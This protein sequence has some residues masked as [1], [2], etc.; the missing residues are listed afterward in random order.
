M[1]GYS[2]QFKTFI[3]AFGGIWYQQ[4]W[5]DK[6]GA[7]FTHSQGLSGGK[8]RFCWANALPKLLPDGIA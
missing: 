3:N 4:G 6:I 1:G 5:K 2:A 8:L 7:R